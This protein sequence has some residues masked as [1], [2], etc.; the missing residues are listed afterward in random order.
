LGEYLKACEAGPPCRLDLYDEV[1][2]PDNVVQY[3]VRHMGGG[4]YRGLVVYHERDPHVATFA[5]QDGDRESVRRFM[6]ALD[7]PVLRI[8]PP[9]RS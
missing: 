8:R 3:S 9:K 2:V 1:N 6:T 4:L 5:G 7:I